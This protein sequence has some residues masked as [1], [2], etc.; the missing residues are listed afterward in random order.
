M[1]SNKSFIAELNSAPK[2]TGGRRV[3]KSRENTDDQ[4]KVAR[5]KV[6]KMV[7]EASRKAAKYQGFRPG[8]I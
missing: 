3:R 4:P 5:G 2:I 6:E 1:V 8:R 7:A